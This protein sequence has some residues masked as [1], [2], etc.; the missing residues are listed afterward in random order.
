MFRRVI[1]AILVASLLVGA[2]AGAETAGV[3]LA[4]ATVTVIRCPTPGESWNAPGTF[5]LTVHCPAAVSTTTTSS[6]TTTTTRPV[7]VTTTT[8]PTTT[9][10][11][12]VPPALAFPNSLFRSPVT[13]WPVDPSSAKIVAD[14]VAAVPTYYGTWGVNTND[15]IYTASAS[16]ATSSFRVTAGCNN[17]VS[18]GTAGALQSAQVPV[19]AGVSATA[20][21]DAPLNIYQPS[22]GLLWELWQAVQSGGQWQACWGGE[23][24]V[25][26]S[27]GVF[28]APYGRS[29]TGISYVATMITLAD[30]AS[31]SIDHAIALVVG[32]CN[33]YVYPADRGDC[34]SDAGQP[35]EGQWFRFAPGTAMPVGLSPFAQMVFRAGLTY[36]FVVVDQGGAYQLQGQ[37]GLD[38]SPT[39]SGQQEYQVV[40]SLPWSHLQV[41]DPPRG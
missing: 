10:P 31:G 16:Q 38:S 8:G 21:S 9:V 34:G 20:S 18:P 19:P 26:T 36:G 23:T 14:M 39:W 30:V 5:P 1:A 37:T 28:P 25:S 4:P 41:V 27:S 6:S 3:N 12:N 13:S 24:N 32:R 33:S 35:A 2:S 11:A 22:T 17:F 29:A 40:N 15:P 7:I